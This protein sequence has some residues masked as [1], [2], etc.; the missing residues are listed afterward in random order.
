MLSYIQGFY[1]LADL[2]LIGAGYAFSQYIV[3]RSGTF[4]IATS[5]LAAIGAYTAA[6]LTVRHGLIPRSQ[7]E[8]RPRRA[9]PRRW[10]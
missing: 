10:F 9:W 3:L 8:S 4:S 2:I 5:G 7:S 1:P 6:I